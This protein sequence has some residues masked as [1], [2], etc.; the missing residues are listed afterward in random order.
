MTQQEAHALIRGI[1]EGVCYLVDKSMRNNRLD[2]Y[3]LGE[4]KD[5]AIDKFDREAGYK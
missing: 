1:M 4:A 3:L 2:S 5:K